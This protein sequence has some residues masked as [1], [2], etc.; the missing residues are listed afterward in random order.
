VKK[1]VL[2]I[3]RFDSVFGLSRPRLQGYRAEF[4][5]PQHNSQN[6]RPEIKQMMHQHFVAFLWWAILS[7]ASVASAMT[8]HMDTV[9]SMA[10]QE[11][12]NL[13]FGALFPHRAKC[14]S[15]EATLRER[16]QQSTERGVIELCS[17]KTIK[18]SSVIDITHLSFELRCEGRSSGFLFRLRRLRRASAPAKCVITGERKTRLFFGSPAFAIFNGIEF[19]DGHA[20]GATSVN[21]VNG[22]AFLIGRIGT[23]SIVAFQHCTFVSNLGKVRE[24]G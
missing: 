12:R 19:R 24:Q 6:S 5:L 16:L 17:G 14:V 9:P 21:G 4:F 7:G 8:E 18:L 20:D 2:R 23:V 3:T 10:P 15:D 11:H 13:L 1:T 22:G